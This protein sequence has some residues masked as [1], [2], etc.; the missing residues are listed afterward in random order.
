M[1]NGP[2]YQKQSRENEKNK[3]ICEQNISKLNLDEEMSDD[4]VEF[5]VDYFSETNKEDSDGC[6]WT[7]QSNE[8]LIRKNKQY[9]RIKN[10]HCLYLILKEFKILYQKM[11]LLIPFGCMEAKIS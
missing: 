9:V 6:H 3:N 2:R 8:K 5:N 4:E 11:I 1:S 7:L 10:K